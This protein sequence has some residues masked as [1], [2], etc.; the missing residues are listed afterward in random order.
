MDKL[1]DEV[2]VM[3]TIKGFYLVHPSETCT[4]DARGSA[5]PKVISIEDDHGNVIWQCKRGRVVKGAFLEF[6]KTCCR[7]ARE[8]AKLFL[9]GAAVVAGIAALGVV[10]IGP[11]MLADKHSLWFLLLYVPHVVFVLFAVGVDE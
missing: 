7:G 6:A 1:R 3:N 4:P 9:F 10:I 2:W 5:D 8:L 11:G